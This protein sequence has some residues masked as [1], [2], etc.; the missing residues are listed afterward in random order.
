MRIL[1]LSLKWLRR[2]ENCNGH[3]LNDTPKMVYRST[4]RKHRAII[5][6]VLLFSHMPDEGIVDRAVLK[7]L[8][9]V[10]LADSVS[11]APLQTAGLYHSIAPPFQD[12]IRSAGFRS[13]YLRG[14]NLSLT[15]L[16]KQ[17]RAKKKAP[18][19]FLII[20]IPSL[21]RDLIHHCHSARSEESY[22]SFSQSAV[23]IASP[24]KTKVSKLERVNT[25]SPIITCQP[26][27]R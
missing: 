26:I 27:K 5:G 13:C 6:S 3:S 8:P 4:E 16:C 7:T 23:I 14:F 11:S 12:R 18:K 21:S 1:R 15:I 9:V 20:V 24:V 25:S 19:G 17:Y 10:L 2:M 22:A